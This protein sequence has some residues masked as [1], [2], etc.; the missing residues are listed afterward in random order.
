[1]YNP[2]FVCGCKGACTQA[3]HPP[4]PSNPTPPKPTQVWK[5]Y[6]PTGSLGDF[7][8]RRHRAPALACLNH[9]VTDALQHVPDCLEYMARLRTPEVFRFC[10]IPQVMAIATLEKVYANPD[11][12][13][14]VV[15]I[16]KGL[17]CKLILEANDMPQ[18]YACFAHFAARVART[19]EGLRGPALAGTATQ[20]RT[21][22]LCREIQS[23]C[24]SKA[25]GTLA[26]PGG[27]SAYAL[28]VV[29]LV[30]AG[31]VAGVARLAGLP[32]PA[33]SDVAAALH[34][35]PAGGV[36]GAV[37]AAKQQLA[38][39]S[40]ADGLRL[41]TCLLAT[42]VLTVV[43]SSIVMA[44]WPPAPRAGA[45]AVAVAGGGNGKAAKGNGAGAGKRK[46]VAASQ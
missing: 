17:A 23:L 38:G 9:L 13:T 43:L 1:M 20:Q 34:R 12:F 41:G 40:P 10:A 28:G 33:P 11:V 8:L 36:D 19:A 2:S 3:P 27:A 46:A 44:V 26:R 14:G 42:F 5:H 16:R 30:G 35:L 22:A 15:K 29:A 32:L 24:A 6:A 7:A 25:G 21:L 45:A 4:H 37:Q 18:L 39:L 31:V